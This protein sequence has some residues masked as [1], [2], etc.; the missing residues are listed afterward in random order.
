[1]TIFP[2]QPP[3]N[4]DCNERDLH[5]EVHYDL[6]DFSQDPELRDSMLF[7]QQYS[8]EPFMTPHQFFYPRVVIELYHTMTSRRE[9][10][11]KAL[12]FSIDY[13]P[14]ILRASDITATFNLSVVLANSAAYRQWPHP[15]PRE[16]VRFL[17]GDTTAGTILFRRQLPPRMLLI[18]HIFRSNLFPLQHIV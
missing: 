8:L 3:G 15:S 12:H 18:D 10:K 4:A 5:A 11:P 16:M 14:G 17:S 6:P 13:R 1:M 7:M 9:P 2:L